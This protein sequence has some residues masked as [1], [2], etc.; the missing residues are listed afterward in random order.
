MPRGTARMRRPGSSR[1]T[2][3]ILLLAGPAAAG[4]AVAGPAVTGPA[5]SAPTATAPD[6]EPAIVHE[7]VTRF[8]DD[9]IREAS[10]LVV[11]GERLFTV[12]DSGDGPH[13]YEVDLRT[14]E[15]L[16]VTTFAEDDPEDVEALAAGSGDAIWVGDIGDNRRVRSSI[17][18][19]RFVP[20]A[21]G[22]RVAAARFRLEYP[23]RPQDAETLLVHPRTGRLHVVTK[24][25]TRG[26]TVY[27][28]PL[29]L[30]PGDTNPLEPMG[31]VPGFLTDGTFLPDGER[32]LL[33]SY[34][35]A[36][37]HAYPSLEQELT[38]PLPPQEQGEA[39]AVG[40]DGRVYVTSEGRGAE[41]LALDLPSAQEAEVA[42]DRVQK[43]R[44]RREPP[45]AYDPQPWM[46]LGPAG[47]LLAVLGS[48][49]AVVVLRE[50]VRAARRRGRRRR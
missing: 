49:L 29:R 20:P 7:V 38:F 28:A 15:T 13:L 27:R 3:L 1:A 12:N 22:G 11:R 9:R 21:G 45:P 35:G 4:P 47:L 25:F 42:R 50:L 18:V 19:Y 40:D 48:A 32:I 44:E 41:V 17:T 46:G 33:R 10:G 43:E 8:T 5:V 16:G 36:T 2:L 34:G 37:V 6:P 24:S 26:G 31:R 30:D 23:D 39:V 14:G